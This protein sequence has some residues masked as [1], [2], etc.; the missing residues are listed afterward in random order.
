M[1]V[2]IDQKN[3]TRIAFYDTHSYEKEVFEEQNQKYNFEIIFFEFKLCRET[4]NSALGFDIVCIFV[5]DILDEATLKILVRCGIKLVA[6]RCSGFNNVDLDAAL[7]CDIT[8]VRVP[9][10]SPDSIAEHTVALILALMRKIPQAAVRTRYGNFMLD[11]LVGRSLA[12]KTVGV[13]GTG[14]I[15]KLTAEILAAFKTKVILYDVTQDVR[16]ATEHGFV[17]VAL[18]EIFTQSDIITLHCPLTKETQH[19][20]NERSLSLVKPGCILVNTSRGALVDAAALIKALKQKKITGAALDVYEEESHYFF[21]DWSN[22]IISDDVLARLL[23]FPNVLLTSHQGFLTQ[24][25]LTSIAKTTMQNIYNFSS[26]RVV[27]NIVWS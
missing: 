13:I 20:V 16:W 22:Q 24:E 27:E 1:S 5:N 15:G 7:K 8:V 2:N 17:Y 6:L 12:G 21:E 9:A 10:Y 4:A 14:R 23:S 26:G 11:G 18:K 3:Y 19:I 25:A